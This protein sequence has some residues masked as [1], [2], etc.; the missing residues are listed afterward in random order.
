MLRVVVSGRAEGVRV[1]G[2]AG[3][4]EVVS[5]M[6]T[7]SV[8]DVVLGAGVAVVVV[9]VGGLT[10]AVVVSLAMVVIVVEIVVL[11]VGLVVVVVVVV[12]VVGVVAGVDGSE[13]VLLDSV[14]NA[15]GVGVGGKDTPRGDN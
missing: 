1:V 9:V 10:V 15:K 14:T 6:V 5:R 12:V 3:D 13:V 7:R 11:V 4:V 2:G 8:D